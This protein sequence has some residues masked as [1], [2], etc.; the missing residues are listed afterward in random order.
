MLFHP[1]DVLSG[2]HQ[3]KNTLQAKKKTSW[4]YFIV[5]NDKTNRLIVKHFELH[6]INLTSL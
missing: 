4:L 1:K 5:R 3:T 6:K 2:D